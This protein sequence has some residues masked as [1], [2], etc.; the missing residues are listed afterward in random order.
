MT[1]NARLP[2]LA[3]RIRSDVVHLYIAK[4]ARLT[5]RTLRRRDLVGMRFI[6]S[7]APKRDALLLV[8]LGM[9]QDE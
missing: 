8:L 3:N 2:R 5:R 6:A 4:Q 1:M 7:A 9:R